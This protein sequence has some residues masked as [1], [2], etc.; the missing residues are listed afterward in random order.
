MDGTTASR[1]AS[2]PVNIE[3]EMR[4][5][6]LDYAMS[7]I[8]GRALPDVRDGL[9][10]VHRRVLYVMHELKNNYNAAYKKSARI[11]GDCIGKYHPHGD[12]AVYDTLVR[13][14][15]DFS[16]RYPLVDGQGNFGSVDGDK[17]AAMRYTE[18][19]MARIAH[20]LLADIDKDTIE[21]GPNYDESTLEPLVLPT[22]VPNLLVN[23][24]AGI[25]V[26]MA[27]NIPPHNLREVIDGTIAV[28][29]NP[30]IGFAE[31]M[32]HITAPDFPT[33]GT[34]HGTAGIVEA[35]RTGRGVIRIRAVCR[36]EEMPGDRE[37]IVVDELPYQVNKARL[38]EKIAELV[39]EKRIE[40]ISDLRDESDRQGM[41]IVIELKR[42]A[43]SQV[44]LNQLYKLTALQ[45]SFGI[46]MLAI[47]HG[48]PRVLTL[49]EVLEHFIDHRRDVTL[50]RTRFDL[51]KA[52]EREHLLEGYVIALDHIDEVI[53]IIRNSATVD[54]AR[55]RLMERFA[56]SERQATAILEM[57]LR[58]LTGLERDEILAELEGIRVE[59]ARLR[60]ILQSEA[61]LLD[62]IEQEL[63]AVRELY[64]DER[65]TRVEASSADFDLADLIPQEDMVVT[66]SHEGYV[67]RVPVSEYRTQRRGG[68]GKSGMATK[69]TDFVEHL[70]VA[71]T[72]STMLFFS[73]AGRVF[74]EQV[75]HLP[76]GS[77]TS[78]GK[79][80]I[81]V[82]PFEG[83]E[84]LAMVLAIPEFVEGHNLFFA[85]ARG[86]VKRTDLMA[87]ANI[88]SSGIIAIKLN[89]DDRLIAVRQTTG[90]S[91]VLL[92]TR[93][94][95][96]IRFDEEDV[97]QMGR[98]A[99]GVR[100]IELGDD[101]EVVGCI[102]FDRG[103]TDEA[104]TWLL[105]VCENGYGKRTLLD[106]YRNQNRGGK[107]LID[108]K[109]SERNGPV[110]G[111]VKVEADTDEYL[112][113]TDH[114]VIIRARAGDV[115]E[116]NRNTLGVR[117]IA[118]DDGAKVVSVARYA[119]GEEEAD[120]SV[121]GSVAPAGESGEFEAGDADAGDFDEDE[122]TDD[123]GG[124]DHGDDDH[125]DHG[126]DGDG[127]DDFGA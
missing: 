5:S 65:R 74:S 55:E 40:G 70:F 42:D 75:F 123:D 76:A 93:E 15:Q 64:G 83:D 97:R 94:G 18:V 60:G 13:L 81:N 104:A 10:P 52:E 50:R 53:D 118:L 29:R 47:V 115:S 17:A 101:D 89:D 117:L 72:H 58:R 28:M 98:D 78:R 69:E 126:D 61:K 66:I 86:R 62:V 12:Q 44:V 107:G 108:I 77:R 124:D 19:R 9:K 36:T 37:R 90:K 56:L 119:E 45:S 49:K 23:G 122:P 99:A 63:I 46:N 27:T 26:G 38:I 20:E 68:R 33:G 51:R 125:D 116:V 14:A 57:R 105:T 88:R 22:K 4:V 32:E 84:K 71:N 109:A 34:I 73:T 54:L 6:Y 102:T 79:P 35:Y 91:D 7:V 120:G 80:I 106:R 25:A 87:Y 43:Q 48:E 121:D 30:D 8:I 1:P 95:M 16:M 96:S 31:L 59:I 103:E 2:M 112:L 24:S 67:K 39:R 127:G 21:F 100:G 111:V 11:V 3:D 113:V 114:G 82:L 110:V 41:R 92:A 85:T